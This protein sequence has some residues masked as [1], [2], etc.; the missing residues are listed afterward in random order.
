M[1]DTGD[2]GGHISRMPRVLSALESPASM[3]LSEEGR[4]SGAGMRRVRPVPLRTPTRAWMAG[5]SSESGVA[6]R[7]V[8]RVD[9]SVTVVA[10]VPS[11]W[12][13]SCE[14]WRPWYSVRLPAVLG[15]DGIAGT[16]GCSAL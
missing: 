12:F 16:G 5:S 15:R 9:T 13:E 6:V 7:T 3:S 1:C 11:L 14:S 10:S 2:T 4:T 8:E